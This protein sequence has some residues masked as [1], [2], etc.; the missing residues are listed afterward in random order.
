[1][2]S[3]SECTNKTVMQILRQYALFDLV[4]RFRPVVHPPPRAK[5]GPANAP[6]AAQANKNCLPEPPI[7]VGNK[8]LV[9]FTGRH[10]HFK[11]S[12]CDICAAKLFTRWDGP[13]EVAEVFPDKWTYSLLLP[14]GEK[15]HPT[16]HVSKLEL[17]HA[18]DSLL[19]P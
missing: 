14:P 16:F 8:V 18:N 10:W 13:F 9:D 19:A 3:C 17:Y 11:S 4:L 5:Q 1:M 6:D 15:A 2:D 7:A 12:G